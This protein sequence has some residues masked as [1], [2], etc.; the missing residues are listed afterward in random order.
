MLLTTLLTAFLMSNDTLDIS[1][2]LK[3]KEVV[4]TGSKQE[5]EVKKR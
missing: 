3:M 4:V 5:T 2:N 1:R